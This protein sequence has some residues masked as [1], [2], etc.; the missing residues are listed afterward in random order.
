MGSPVFTFQRMMVL[1]NDALARNDPS[2]ENAILVT[3]SE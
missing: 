2:V 1:S 3:P